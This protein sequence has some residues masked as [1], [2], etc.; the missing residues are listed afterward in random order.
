M[1]DHTVGGVTS[2]RVLPQHYNARAAAGAMLK[3][4]SAEAV[5]ALAEGQAVTMRLV[6][7]DGGQWQ[8]IM[9][10][11]EDALPIQLPLPLMELRS[12]QQ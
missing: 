11:H 7:C 3:D 4:V 8:I 12:C 2:I 10:R 9:N 6:G 1:C 5:D